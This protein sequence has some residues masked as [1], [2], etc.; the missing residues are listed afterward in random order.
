MATLSAR[1]RLGSVL[2]LLWLCTLALWPRS[3]AAQSIT[4]GSLRVDVVGADGRPVVEANV[5]LLDENDV[6][7]RQAK[8]DFRGRF[9][10]PL[11]GPGRYSLRVE[12][13]GYQPLRQRGV[14]VVP[15]ATSIV[16]VQILRRPPPITQVEEVPVA[17]QQISSEVPL[18]GELAA[19][20]VSPYFSARLD[21]TDLAPNTANASEPRDERAGLTQSFGGLPQ[22]HSRMMVDGL[23]AF[24]FRHP[25]IEG[26]PGRAPAYP[27]YLV[28]RGQLV[29]FGLDGEWAGGNSGELSAIS[30]RGADR[31]RFEPFAFWS[32][33]LGVAKAQNPG[34]SS[35]TSFLVG[36]VASGVLVRGKANFLA[37]FHYQQLD[38]PVGRPWEGDSASFGGTPIGLTAG[39]NQIAADSFGATVGGFTRP[40]VRSSRGGAG[41]FRVDWRLSPTNTISTRADFARSKEDAPE[42]GRDILTD[43]ASRLDNRDFSGGGSWTWVSGSTANEFRFGVRTTERDWATP[44]LP[45]T[46]FS[47]LDAGIGGLASGPANFYRR[48]FDFSE[49]FHQ[50]WGNSEQHRFKVGAQYSNSSYTQDYL[51]GQRGIYQFGGLDEFGQGTGSFLIRETG[52]PRVKYTV[53]QYGVFGQLTYR[54]RPALSL[55]VGLRYDRQVFPKPN[56][57]RGSAP[58]ATLDTAFVRL[59]GL[60]NNARPDDNNDIG[61]RIGLTWEGRGA[62]PLTL[63]AGY[64]W[65]Y[66]ELNLARYAEAAVAD[67][68]GLVARRGVG[69][70][71]WPALPDTVA[72]PSAGRVITLFSP[73]DDYKNPRTRKFDLQIDKN[74][75][76]GIRARAF[77]GYHHTDFLL[78]RDD[79][80]LLAAAA[81][82]T[83]EGRPVYGTLVQQGGLVVATPGSNRRLAGF[84][85]VSAL[86]STGFSDYYQAGLS[87]SRESTRGLGFAASY[88]WSRTRDNWLQS[89]NG[90]PTDELSPFPQDRPGNEWAEGISDFDVPHRASVLATWRSSGAVPFS[91]GARYRYRSGYSYTPGFPDGVDAN[92]DGSGRNDPAFVDAA[93]P[94]MT[95]II[96]ANDCLKDQVGHFAQRN[97]CRDQANHALDLNASIGLPVR[98]LGGR[99]ELMV[100]VFNLASTTS[101]LIDQALVRVD[102]AGTLTT[103]PQGNVTLPLLA[104]PHFGKLLARRSE[105]RIV[106]LGLRLDY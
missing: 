33:G 66:G 58:T 72:A 1:R 84:D 49:A 47:G 5:A 81:G 88:L 30:R 52:D 16:R 14:E 46:Y 12:K 45:T 85:M 105:P 37:G 104:N 91:L 53:K 54:L 95:S 76:N 20:D 87:I 41:G 18:L 106:R 51:F 31:F 62:A 8:S 79:I 35:L 86:V 40:V 11:L 78:R 3:L 27:S 83:Q 28:Q 36:A 25:G 67:G 44:V 6:E 50:A 103:D 93:L 102:P 29:P 43:A 2:A 34:D 99:L 55:L 64:G 69:A 4:E 98:S 100:D 101:G 9:S 70:L 68:D 80:N 59:T 75:S 74:F 19:H 22:S 89:W 39:I 60:V 61:P 13:T 15:A 38:L 92:G 21:L 42:L 57:R 26:E 10:V 32:G 56:P 63:S 97:S 77:G 94:G 73:K 65:Q 7:L 96:G 17:N 23:P 90:D 48:S 82:R 71:T 24:S